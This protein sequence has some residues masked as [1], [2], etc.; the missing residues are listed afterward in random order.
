MSKLK[1][2]LIVAGGDGTLMYI[3]DDAIKAGVNI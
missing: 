3:V 1:L 2:Y